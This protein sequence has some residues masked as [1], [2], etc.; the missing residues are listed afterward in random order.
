MK[1][2]TLHQSIL[3]CVEVWQLA[4]TSTPAEN[5]FLGSMQC[6]NGKLDSMLTLV[7]NV[8]RAPPKILRLGGY[9]NIF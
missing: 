6:K 2:F 1:E 4:E 3:M 7:P 9:Q 8:D 5:D